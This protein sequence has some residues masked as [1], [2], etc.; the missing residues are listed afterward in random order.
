MRPTGEEC[1]TAAAVLLAAKKEAEKVRVTQ[2]EGGTWC[3]ARLKAGVESADQPIMLRNPLQPRAVIAGTL[4]NLLPATPESAIV[5]TS[6]TGSP[7]SDGDDD[8]L[9][10][11]FDTPLPVFE[12]RGGP[13]ATQAASQGA[14]EA[15]G[16]D[17]GATQTAAA[18]APQAVADPP[19]TT[20][21]PAPFA[22][23]V[24]PPRA[25]IGGGGAHFSL[26]HEILA[27]AHA[28]IPSAVRFW[29]F[30]FSEA[31]VGGLPTPPLLG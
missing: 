3:G 23:P 10:L 5:L 4:A 29:W 19:P 22:A 1:A 16:A 17:Q 12:D 6:G 13:E 26:H 21:P 9:T 7:S 15:V 31:C 8:D 28:A 24:P 11:N 25:V 30:R 18:P 2:R 14:A 20:A 27:F